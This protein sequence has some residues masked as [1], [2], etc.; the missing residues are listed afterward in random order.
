MKQGGAN[1]CESKLL[2][3]HCALHPLKESV[4]QAV[5]SGSEAERR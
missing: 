3:G 4:E 1:S 2:A 5:P